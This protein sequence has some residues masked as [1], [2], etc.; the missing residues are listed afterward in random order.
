M[1]RPVRAWAC[2]DCLKASEDG[3]G[4]VELVNRII[5]GYYIEMCE[6]L[7]FGDSKK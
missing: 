1:S 5:A 7:M 6:T 4:S 2:L 3:L